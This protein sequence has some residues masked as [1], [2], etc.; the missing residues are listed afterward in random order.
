MTRKGYNEGCLAAHALDLIGDRWAL[1]V[2]R[3]LMLGPKRF[4]LIRAGLPGIATNILTQRLDALEA[5]GLLR[6]HRLPSPASVPVYELTEAG[7]GTRDV[8]DALCRWGVQQPG[9]DPTKFISPTALMLSMRVMVRPDKG[10]VPQQVGFVMGDERFT[11]VLDA[12]GF[13]PVPA[14][15][16]L[17]D[18]T[19]TGTGNSLA[20]AV[21]GP[22]PVAQLAAAGTIGLS[23]DA[24]T[25]QHVVDAFRLG[26]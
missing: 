23:G 17:P 12:Q 16:A 14:A 24:E 21:Y 7:L 18:L 4:G 8:I 3:E 11:A 2:L 26:A 15:G 19:F 1:L 6:H 25:A 9:H 10:Q 13:A 20:I 22:V 5:S